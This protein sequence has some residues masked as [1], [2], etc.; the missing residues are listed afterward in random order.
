MRIVFW[1]TPAFAVPSLRALTDEGH[2]IAAV[3]T[4][5][6]RPAGRGRRLTPSPVKEVAEAEGIEVLQPERPRGEAFLERLAELAPDLS[7][8]VAYGHILRSEVLDLPRLGSINVHASLLPELRGAAP[9]NWAIARGH[10]KTGVTI[11]RMTPGMDEGPILLQTEEPIGPE[12][13]ASE[14]TA[15][16][17]E[18]GAEALVEAL[19]LIDAGAIEEREQ[20]HA[21]ATYAPK[22]DRATARIDWSRP[23]HEVAWHVRGMDAVPGAWSTLEGAPVKLFRPLPD[24]AVRA[25]GPPGTV[26]DADPDEGVLVA[27]GEGAVWLREVQ[28]AGR[29]RMEAGAWVRGRGVF[30]G[31]RFVDPPEAGA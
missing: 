18:L 24:P 16:L 26:V 27:C 6:D 17:S 23:A 25:E 9:I 19:T 4:Q 14:L 2:D 15:R 1:G 31:Q 7:V 11:M 29:K 3:V 13:T 20:D 22:V 10:Q 30:A 5:P 21:R 28:P 8:V 12:E